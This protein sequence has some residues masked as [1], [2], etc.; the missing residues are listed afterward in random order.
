MSE[1]NESAA[2]DYA[3][4]ALPLMARYGV[5]PTP[6][7]YA[8][9][10]VY[11][12]NDDSELVHE[13][14]AIIKEKLTFT[15]DIS[16]YLYAKYISETDSRIVHQTTIGIR[17]VM[18]DII[19]NLAN[20]AGEADDY[21]KGLAQHLET[22]PGVDEKGVQAIIAALVEQAGGMLDSSGSI[23]DKLEASR[24]EIES[25]KEDLAQVKTESERDFLTGVYNRKALDHKLE[26]LIT[27]SAAAK[28]P[29]CML[30]LD[31]DH[32][33]QFNDKHGHLIG[34]EVLKIVARSL[35]DSVKGKD[36]VARFGGEEFAVLLPNTPVGGAMIVAENIRKTIATKELKRRDTGETY[37]QITVSIGVAMHRPSA[38]TIPTFI[39]RADEALYRAKNSGRNCV[40]QERLKKAS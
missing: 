33:K 9:W 29:L 5:E 34:D 24:K 17:Q 1:G 14:D 11:V 18:T 6:K 30:M 39:K 32:F 10:Y 35:T 15:D 40:T 20:F 2:F 36:V 19:S 7:N 23:T 22:I 16:E 27:E 13:V 21:K 3:K 38:D 26:E 8:I 4:K 28:E 25:L 12:A 31:V 37:G